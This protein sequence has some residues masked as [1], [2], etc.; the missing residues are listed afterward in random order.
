MSAVVKETAPV[1][2]CGT[3]VRLQSEAHARAG[4]LAAALAGAGIGRGARVAVLLRNDIE[5]LE[6]SLAVA[7]AGANP[8]PVNTRWQAPEVAHVLSDSGARLVIAHTEF[9][10]VVERAVEIAA[11]AVD[12]VEVAMPVELLAEAGLEPGLQAPTGRYATLEQ[13]IDSRPEQLGH[14]EGAIADSMGLIYTSGTTGR[15]KGV[16]RD[17]MTPEQLLSIAGGSARRMGLAPGGEMLVAGPLYH[18]SP[19]A[20][21]VLGLR[22]GTNITV[23]PRFDAECFLRHVHTHRVTQAKVVPTM[24]SRLLSL[25]EDVRARYD[26]SSLTHLIH[27]AAPCSAAVKRAAIDWFG[28]AVVEFYGC[29]EAGTITWISAAEWLAH[30]GSVGRPADGSGVVVADDHGNP[31]PP[32]EIGRVYVRG[33]DYWPGFTYLGADEKAGPVAGFIGVGDTG[34]LD[35]DGFLYLTGRSSEIVIRGG[36]N[37]YPAEIENAVMALPG[38]EDVAVFGI[39]DTGDLGEAVVAHVVPRPGTEVTAETIRSGLRSV[40]AAFKLPTTIRITAALP[41]DDSGKIRKHLLRE[42][43]SQ[44]L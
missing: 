22:M 26:V 24:L 3:R 10:D 9:V 30:P 38:V 19:N 2:R 39:P 25:P 32:G 18:T 5:F 27:S 33:A 16:V 20:V 1:I 23:M 17:R 8:V 42:Q 43:Y 7:A 14:I 15:P 41:R 35:A 29:T 12:L 28:D 40:L 6:V 34:Y 13:W 4:R 11:T 37:I 31:L 36:V 44:R 21:A